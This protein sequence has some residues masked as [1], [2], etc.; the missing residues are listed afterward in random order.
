[1]GK[2]VKYMYV[3]KH[4]NVKYVFCNEYL[5]ASLYDRQRNLNCFSVKYEML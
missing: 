4:K 1:M 3:Y 2:H 5:N